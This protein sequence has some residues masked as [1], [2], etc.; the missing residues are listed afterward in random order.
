[1]LLTFYILNFG[2]NF[3]VTKNID[4]TTTSTTSSTTTQ[5]SVDN[6]TVQIEEMGYVKG[7]ADDRYNV[8]KFLGNIFFMFIFTTF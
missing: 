3:C 4:T 8:V 1:M 7:I 5:S 2:T 6:L